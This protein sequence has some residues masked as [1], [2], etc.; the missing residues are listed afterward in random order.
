MQK[1][2]KGSFGHAVL[3]Q[4]L[5]SNAYFVAKLMKYKNLETEQKDFILREVRTMSQI[6][7]EG[8]HPYLV[9]LRESFVLSTGM[10]ARR[11]HVR[12]LSCLAPSSYGMP[13]AASLP[14]AHP[15]RL[16]AACASSW[17]FAMVAI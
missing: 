6:S 13:Y 12:R 8:G 10:C 16:C 1:L 11:M 9:R 14:D 5:E 3:V 7:Q 2:G 17:T 4:R 15:R